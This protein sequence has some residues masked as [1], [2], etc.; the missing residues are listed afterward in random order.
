[1]FKIEKISLKVPVLLK[2]FGMLRRKYVVFIKNQAEI[3]VF[4]KLIHKIKFL[5]FI[6]NDIYKS[7]QYI[8][9]G[10][11]CQIHQERENSLPMKWRELGESTCYLDTS[12]FSF[13]I[14]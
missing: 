8:Q 11:R 10:R 6:N 5:K 1:M 4:L 13:Q 12:F 2:F 3:Q 9:S 7:L 14:Y